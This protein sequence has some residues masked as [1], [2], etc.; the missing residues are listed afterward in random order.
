MD[1]IGVSLGA[2]SLLF[3]VFAGC[4]KAYQLISEASDFEKDYQFIRIRFKTEQYRLLDFASVAQLTEKDETLIINPSNRTIL[5]DVL[6]QQS[7]MIMRFGHFDERLRPFAKPLVEAVLEG[8]TGESKSRDP[9]ASR[10]PHSNPILRKALDFTKKSAT[11][12]ARL[13][14]VV[15]DR[16][17]VEELLSRLVASNNFLQELLNTHQLQTL[18]Q[19]EVQTVYQIMQ[20]NNRLDQVYE[21]VQAGL[22][23]I[24]PEGGHRLGHSGMGHAGFGQTT[25]LVKA[26]DSVLVSK[27]VELGQF[28]AIAAAADEGG[29]TQDLRENMQLGSVAA[30]DLPLQLKQDDIILDDPDTEANEVRVPGWYQPKGTTR[31]RVWIEWKRM[32]PR[33]IY[34][35]DDGPDPDTL[36]RFQ[37]LVRLL[38]EHDQVRHFRAPPCLG[39]YL[40]A[41]TPTGI[42]YGL[43]FQP[44]PSTDPLTPPT[45]LRDILTNP[46]FP[47][48]SLTSRITLMHTIA[49]AVEKLHSV[50][51]L[52]KSLCASNIIFFPAPSPASNTS[53][54]EP[55]LT[56]FDYS[57]P[58]PALSMSS[59]S[60]RTTSEDLYR[61]PGVQGQPREGTRSLGYR[62]RH[63]IYS[64][65]VVLTEIAYWKPIEEVLG[66]AEGGRGVLFDGWDEFIL[67]NSWTGR[68]LGG[69]TLDCQIW[70]QS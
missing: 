37:A 42:R 6:D 3:Q 46:S 9:L 21:I 4:V 35:A 23:P 18:R 1:P 2:A 56:G 27:L 16:A 62:K 32:D 54:D 67:A 41:A 53:L 70:C 65:G 52:H 48:P 8:D 43:V 22:L 30:N 50:N 15:F 7:K 66:V 20:L 10:F 47:P 26:S 36:R 38:R 55:Y 5:L 28:K 24:T 34:N 64:L 59:S 58:S 44:P 33:H 19:V 29:L 68:L 14:W 11:Y 17:K 63:D 57:R 40:H 49:R 12:P 45:S 25:D 31:S 61:H 39:Y 51:W 60:P 13:R 69:A